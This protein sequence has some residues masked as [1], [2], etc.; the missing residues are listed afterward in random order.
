MKKLIPIILVGMLCLSG[1]EAAEFQFGL[2]GGLRSVSD[3]DMSDIYGSGLWLTPSLALK[4]NSQLSLGLDF[5]FGFS[6]SDKAIG[7]MDDPSDFS[8]S[9]L[10]LFGSYRFPARTVTPYLKLA[11][12]FAFYSQVIEAA[13]VDF[14]KSALCVRLAGGAEYPLTDTFSLTGELGYTILS[15]EPLD[16]RVNLGGISAQLGIVCHFTL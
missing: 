3:A 7:V 5:S 10:E 16:E 12:G 15:V 6:K 1:I 13:A 2:L 14:A 9:Q 4:L 8:M 11:M